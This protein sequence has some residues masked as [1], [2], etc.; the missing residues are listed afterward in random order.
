MSDATYGA[1]IGHLELF[2]EWRHKIMLR[3]GAAVAGTLVAAAWLYDRS[4]LGAPRVLTAVTL[5]AGAVLAVL[6]YLM[7]R[8]NTELIE[9]C[10][11]QIREVEKALG[12][13]TGPGFAALYPAGGAGVY[14]R[15]LAAVYGMAVV[16]LL[17]LG[18]GALTVDYG[19]ST[20]VTTIPTKSK[21][22]KPKPTKSNS[23]PPKTTTSTPAT[24]TPAP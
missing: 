16:G 10:R 17:G 6:L 20:P 12:V 2:Y 24:S 1:L 8:R 22:A 19:T 18:I 9:R 15:L 14:R 13:D 11:Q 5:F 3:L 7:E 21:A 23:A 4:A